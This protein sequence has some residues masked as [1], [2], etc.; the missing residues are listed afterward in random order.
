MIAGL[1]LDDERIPS[2]ASWMSYPSN[3]SWDIVRNSEDFMEA[4]K[5]KQYDI[6][7]FDHDI[8]DWVDGKEVTGYDCL[9][10]YC[11]MGMSGS[12]PEMYFHS[13]NPVGRNNM[14]LYWMNYLE[15]FYN[16]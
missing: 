7:S 1:F 16:E 12:E 15:C 2:S 8:Q 4:V 13:Q 6:I 5:S 14:R 10:Q 3:V 9:K 11:Y